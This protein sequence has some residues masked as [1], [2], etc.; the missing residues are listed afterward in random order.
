MNMLK[1]IFMHQMVCE[2][3]LHSHCGSK[4]NTL[5]VGFLVIPRD[6]AGMSILTSIIPVTKYAKADRDACSLLMQLDVSN[7]LPKLTC[8]NQYSIFFLIKWKET[9]SSQKPG[10]RVLCCC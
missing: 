7:I 10:N 6:H 9:L 8:N 2:K 1:M 4:R 5:E 3:T